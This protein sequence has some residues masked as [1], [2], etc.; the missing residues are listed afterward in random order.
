[1]VSVTTIAVLC[2]TFLQVMCIVEMSISMTSTSEQQ[3][4]VTFVRPLECPPG[5]L[6]YNGT[7]ECECYPNPNVVCDENFRDRA[8]LT[9]G[10]CMTYEEGEGTFF[11]LCISFLAH[12][13]NVSNRAF[14]NL[15]G[16]LTDLND[17]MCG[18][19]NRQ[20]IICSKCIDGFAPAITSLGF[21]CSNC[22]NAWYGIPLFLVLEFVPIT[23]FFLIIVSFGF[24]VTSAPMTSFVLFSQ[25]AAH[26]FTAFTSLTAILENEYGNGLLYFIKVVTSFYG[27][28][29][30]DFFRYVIPPFCISP[31]LKLI[32]IFSFY[33]ISAFYP[34]VLIGIT[35]I[36]IE[37]HSRNFKFLT[38]I[39][40]YVRKC[41]C[42]TRKQMNKKS[43]VIEVFATFFLLSYT[44]LFFTSFYFLIYITIEKD[45]SLFKYASGL[46]P[47]TG[48]FSKNHAPFAIFAIFVLIGPVLIPVLIL[49]CSPVRAFR[50]LLQKCK[51]SG[52]SQA[53]LN[54]FV[55]KFYSCYRDGLE[56]GKDLRC[57]VCL[58][59]LLR[60]T[61]FF[62]L[63]TQSLF[64]FWFFYFVFF[65]SAS[66][67]IAIVQPYKKA[68][69]NILDSL[70]LANLALFGILFILYL[71]FGL[72]QHQHSTFFL[73]L[74]LI[75]FS[76]PLLGFIFVVSFTI[77]KDKIPANWIKVCNKNCCRSSTSVSLPEQD[78]EVQENAQ[79]S[80]TSTTEVELP[81]RILHPHRYVEE[82]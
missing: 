53:A 67:L 41:N 69:M 68:Y 25:L 38:W 81:D 23:V 42:H 14:L 50:S 24:S 22:T 39:W 7:N 34:L 43:T 16:N 62:G 74:L 77:F 15:P 44:K 56:G 2:M 63:V 9:F 65:A 54:L 79:V 3:S 27:I 52:H 82:S 49:S 32:H 61:I 57:F 12:G 4:E 55:E 8:S 17:Y 1:M 75:T 28:W 59:F 26:L 80:S 11:G 40:Q 10:F 71:S 35:W 33:Y 76:L 64:T 30:L 13:R 21:Q 5:F 31:H 70:I 72:N 36:C 66:L 48:Y 78:S 60:L 73:V 6:Y 45:G 37:L 47:E 51:I 20:G 18:P 29:N 46:D 58:P 19:M